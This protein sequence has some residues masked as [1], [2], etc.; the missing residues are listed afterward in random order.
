MKLKYYPETDSLYIDLA[1]E[2]GIETREISKGINLDYDAKG[3]IVG[4]DID[5]SSKKLN[6]IELVTSKFPFEKQVIS[7]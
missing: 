6:L 3:N 1:E 2:A 5:N 7:V 4:I